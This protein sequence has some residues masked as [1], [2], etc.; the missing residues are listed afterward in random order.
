MKKIVLFIIFALS[1]MCVDVYGA[2]PTFVMQSFNKTDT[3]Y[4]VLYDFYNGDNRAEYT[5]VTGIY[6]DNRQIGLKR[7]NIV[8]EANS[9]VMKNVSFETDDT[10]TTVRAMAFDSMTTLKPM[11]K[12]GELHIND[13]KQ[14]VIWDFSREELV[15]LGKITQPITVNGLTLNYSVKDMTVR[16]S[17]IGGYGLNLYG[18]GKPTDCSVSF[19]AGKGAVVRLY[20][21]STNEEPRTIKITDKNKKLLDS[22]TVGNTVNI[23]DFKSDDENEIYVYSASSGVYIYKI[24][25]LYNDYYQRVD[26]IY[27]DNYENLLSAVSMLTNSSDGNIYLQSDYISCNA[28]LV[29]GKANS[30][31]TISGAEGYTPVLDFYPMLK[32][33]INTAESVKQNS[34]LIKGSGY[35]LKNFIIQKCAGSAIK[36]NGEN[37]FNNTVENVVSRYNCGG[38]FSITNGAFNNTLKSCDAY[39]NCDVYT[40]GGNA[41]GFILSIKAGTGNKV[42]NCRAWENSDDGFD[43]FANHNDIYYE[44]CYA[45]DNGNPNVFTG[46]KDYYN[47]K[48]LDKNMLLIQLILERD[49]DFEQRY[50][51]RKGIKLPT[52]AFIL[53]SESTE[54]VSV[55][56]L[57]GAGWNGNPNGFKLGS[58]YSEAH[59]EAVGE[60][61]YRSLKNCIAFDHLSRGVDRNNCSAHLDLQN[62]ISFDNKKNYWLDTMVVR[63][64][65]ENA[66]GFGGTAADTVNTQTMKILLP[67]IEVQQRMENEIRGFMSEIEEKAY[68]NQ[69]PGEMIYT[70]YQP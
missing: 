63:S 53:G 70:D 48:P 39:R 11:T 13:E 43:N 28:P 61:A 37:C 69:I 51:E 42:Y 19:K 55:V 52:D 21:S 50:N 12:Y 4:R 1:V 14:S 8:V 36:L 27:V 22:Y 31:L 46:L 67:I 33:L 45:W 56:Y 64:V 7:E 59:G 66:I 54:P 49:P 44:N 58:G 65:F 38:G 47:N 35:T 5:L 41:D 24:E 9:R 26:N 29:L 3:G 40:L 10:C 34:I 32:P 20:T 25:V 16:V 2:E 30:G 62:V 6:N 57:V 23:H 17:N 15:S 68:N 18:G 60:E